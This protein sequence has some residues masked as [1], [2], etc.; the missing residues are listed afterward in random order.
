[1]KVTPEVTKA[2]GNITTKFLIDEGPRDVIGAFRIE[3]NQSVPV[4]KLA[5]KGLNIAE[6]QPYSAK[7]VDQDRNQII[8]QYLR[9]G[10]LNAS[11]RARAVK[12]NNDPHKLEVVYEITEGPRVTIDSVATLGALRTRQ[13][14]IDRTTQLRPENP[15]RE[16]DLFSA[17]SKL[18]NLN[19]FD[20]AE[21][22]PRRQ[23]TTQT[24]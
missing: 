6:G 13:S 10:Y 17:E 3:G 11:F 22:D 23:I 15:L 2:G 9:T 1:M 20:W 7:K 21:I 8:A 18:Y 24:E 16:D 19:I 4:E 14:V 12:I 5:P